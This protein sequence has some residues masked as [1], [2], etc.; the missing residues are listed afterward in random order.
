MTD[1]TAEKAP[2]KAVKAKKEVVERDS[3][4]GITRP[5]AGTKTGIVWAIADDLSAKLKE[6]V[7]RKAVLEAAAGKELNAATAATQYGRWRKYNGLAGTGKEAS[8]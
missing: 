7:G 5:K 4:N 2:A 3:A 8:A 6:P 1:K